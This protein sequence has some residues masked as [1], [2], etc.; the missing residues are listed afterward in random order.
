MSIVRLPLFFDPSGLNNRKNT[1]LEQALA[2]KNQL[3][4]DE[5]TRHFNRHINHGRRCN[6]RP[7]IC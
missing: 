2:S 3:L 1:T 6:K 4:A 7:N 5:K